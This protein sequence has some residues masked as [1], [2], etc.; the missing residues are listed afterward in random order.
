MF[1]CEKFID[2]VNNNL[3]RLVYEKLPFAE[4]NGGCNTGIVKEV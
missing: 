2:A 4:N 1:G 3:S